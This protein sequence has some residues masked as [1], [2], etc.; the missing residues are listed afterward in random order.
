MAQAYQNRSIQPHVKEWNSI[1][2]QTLPKKDE[3]LFSFQT[4]NDGDFLVL[5]IAVFAKQD[6]KLDFGH[7]HKKKQRTGHK[8]DI[9]FY[10][11]ISIIRDVRGKIQTL[12]HFFHS[13]CFSLVY[14]FN[15]IS[16][17]SDLFNAEI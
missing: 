5:N 6:I 1:E 10:F 4:I 14:F 16:T 2:Q 13:I 9:L 11:Q 8:I 7:N 15:G 12:K 17:P 3:K